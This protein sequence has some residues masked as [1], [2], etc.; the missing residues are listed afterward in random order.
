MRRFILYSRTG[1]TAPF[2]GSLLEAGRLDV[3]HQCIISAMFLSHSIRRDVEFHVFLYGSPNPPLHIIIDGSSLY[4]VRTDE[5]TWNKILNEILSGH[6]HQGIFM[7]KEGIENYVETLKKIFVL[8][9]KGKD[10]KEFERKDLD[11]ASFIIG[12]QV[13]LPI[14]FEKFVRRLGANELSLG[15]KR[16]LASSVI[17]IINYSLDRLMV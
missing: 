7:R 11:D 1:K 12:D 6:P 17:N 2:N 4:D 14:K 13:G 3:I 16:Y 9:E 5:A 8:N 15:K 10:I